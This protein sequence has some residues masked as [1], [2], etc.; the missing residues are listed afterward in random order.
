MAIE[1]LNTPLPAAL[2]AFV[3]NITGASGSFSDADEYIRDL[4]RRDMERREILWSHPA[5][6]EG[7]RDLADGRVFSSTFDFKTDMA[8]LDKREA[9]AWT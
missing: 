9:E 7:F 8:E 1:H 5:I 3:A 6:E 4:I 2:G